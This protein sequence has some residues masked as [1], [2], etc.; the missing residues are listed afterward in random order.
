MDTQNIINAN[1]RRRSSPTQLDLLSLLVHLSAPSRFVGRFNTFSRS[2][3]LTHFPSISPFVTSVTS[4]CMTQQ[5]CLAF[6]YSNN[7]LSCCLA[8]MYSDNGLSCCLAFMYSDNGLSCCLAFMYSDNG[9]SCCLAFMYSDNGL[10]C[11]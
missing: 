8:F 7:G 3:T 4:H 2:F 5:C 11:S 6:M 10:S 1:R 9:L